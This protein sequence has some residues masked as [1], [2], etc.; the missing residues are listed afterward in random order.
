MLIARKISYGLARL[1]IFLLQ[2]EDLLVYFLQR[3]TDPVMIKVPFR[4]RR[5]FWL[6]R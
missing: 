3:R 5:H 1:R 4:L 2:A 6:S